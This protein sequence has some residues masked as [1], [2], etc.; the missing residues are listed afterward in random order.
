MQFSLY[1][2][3]LFR[4]AFLADDLITCNFM[5]YVLYKWFVLVFTISLFELNVNKFHLECMF[6]MNECKILCCMGIL[7]PPSSSNNFC[8]FRFWQ[9]KVYCSNA[10]ISIFFHRKLHTH[11]IE[12]I[13]VLILQAECYTG[14]F[15]LCY[16]HDTSCQIIVCS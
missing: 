16:I 14:F 3:I 10:S 15:P 4:W 1:V 6:S 12:A 7:L 11:I 5:I 8:I 13:S 9:V 2:P